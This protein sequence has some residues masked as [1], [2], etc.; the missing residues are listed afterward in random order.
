MTTKQIWETYHKDLYQFIISKVKDTT[1]AD[2]ILQETFIKIHVKLSSLQ[3]KSK[4]RSWIFAIARNTIYDYFRISGNTVE[5]DEIDA[6]SDEDLDKKTDHT[7]HDCLL[8]IMLNMPKKYREPLF[9]Y[10]IKGIK[11]NEIS[12]Q[13]QLPL[14]TVKSQIQRARKKVAQGFMDCCGFVMNN[15]GYLVGEVKP[16]ED[17]KIC[18]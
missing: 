5:I 4:L 13:L 18:R 15:E 10:D 7:A 17:C 12:E 11:Q 8:G 14:A 1:I 16:I 9:L 2:D 3:D 6:V